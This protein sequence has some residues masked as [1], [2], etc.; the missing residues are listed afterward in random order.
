MTHNYNGTWQR[1]NWRV[2]FSKRKKIIMSCSKFSLSLVMS[3]ILSWP[4][5]RGA[6]RHHDC[7]RY[8]E[9]RSRIQNSRFLFFLLYARLPQGRAPLKSMKDWWM[10][11]L[12][13]F[14]LS[15][16]FTDREIPKS[17]SLTEKLVA[18]GEAT[19]MHHDRCCLRNTTFS[20]QVFPVLVCFGDM[21]IMVP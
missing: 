21:G 1:H 9:Y 11:S 17:F 19:A 12:S 10:S 3:K 18:I 8:I 6:Y 13:P 20:I 14:P 7:A 15:G 16:P 4:H 5:L 2:Y